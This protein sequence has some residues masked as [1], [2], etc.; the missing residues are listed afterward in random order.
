MKKKRFTGY[1][2]DKSMSCSQRKARQLRN[3]RMS[4]IHLLSLQALPIEKLERVFQKVRDG[5]LGLIG[6]NEE[7]N[8][9]I[10]YQGY[11]KKSLRRL[12]P[13]DRENA[14]E[15]DENRIPVECGN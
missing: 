5:E 13:A 15:T 7:P 8:Q 3:L 2:R 11:T 12:A 4:R 9:K 14:V 1:H 10:C 6:L